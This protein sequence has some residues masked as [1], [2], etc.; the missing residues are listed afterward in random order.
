MRR[1]KRGLR[2]SWCDGCTPPGGARMHAERIAV[3]HRG[4]SRAMRRMRKSNAHLVLRVVIL[5]VHD[6]TGDV[7]LLLHRYNDQRT[8]QEAQFSGSTNIARF[9]PNQKLGLSLCDMINWY[10]NEYQLQYTSYDNYDNT[11]RS[12]NNERRIPLISNPAIKS[13]NLIFLIHCV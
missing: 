4:A 3:T 6:N 12:M 7:A 11:E 13:W 1:R 9:F 8:W 2:N 10:D 5:C